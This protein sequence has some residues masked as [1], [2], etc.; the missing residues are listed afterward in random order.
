MKKKFLKR[1]GWCIVLIFII[2][3]IVI[4]GNAIIT[5][6]DAIKNN[7]VTIPKE[8][9]IEYISQGIMGLW[10]TDGLALVGLI[11]ALINHLFLKLP[12]MK[13]FTRWVSLNYLNDNIKFSFEINFS[14]EKIDEISYIK[15]I[16]FNE[17]N[18]YEKF[19]STNAENIIEN[20]NMFKMTFLPL[21]STLEVKKM[22]NDDINNESKRKN[23]WKI[24][25]TG[26]CT[27]KT[28]NINKD[29]ILERVIEALQTSAINIEKI[30]LNF[31][32]EDSQL[33][34]F[35]PKKYNLNSDCTAEFF[36][37]KYSTKTNAKITLDS[38]KGITLYANNKNAFKNAYEEFKNLLIN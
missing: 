7:I 35:N 33:K 23:Y 14:S 6:F 2:I 20:T 11:I 22:K 18:Q 8:K 36:S 32:K 29:F 12:I 4:K 9:K 28:I 21:A 15:N 19:N 30:H 17:A 5:S 24:T 34:V 16:I 38:N 1:I 37:V 25:N 31:E 26:V 27:F 13:K 10:N 3:A